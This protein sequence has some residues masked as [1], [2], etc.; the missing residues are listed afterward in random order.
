MHLASAIRALA[1]PAAAALLLLGAPA[2]VAQSDRQPPQPN[3]VMFMTDD[4]S[5]STVLP[6]VMPNLFEL[7]INRGSS[8]NDFVVTTPLCCPSRATALT[9][10]YGHNNRVLRNAYRLLADKRN[11]LPRWLQLA[12]Y[13]TAHVG[14]FLNGYERFAE[15]ARD[16]APG[17]DLWFT[18]LQPRQYYNWKA[19]KNGKLRRFGIADEHNL[20]DVTNR[21]AVDW[22]RKL[23]RRDEP[24]Y[25]QLD[26][27][28]PHG[29]PGRD[30]SCPGAPAPSPRDQ[31]FFA[32]EPLPRPPNFNEA[33]VSDK[34]AFIQERPLM[35]AETIERTAVRYRCTLE[36]LR[37]VDRGI[38]RVY[39][40]V[41]RAGQL[42]RTI[43]IFSSDNGFFFGEHRIP[44]GKLVPYEETLRMPLAIRT[45]PRYRNRAPRRGT[46]G[47]T[48]ANIDLAPTILELAGAQPCMP[49]GRCR[50]MD[51]RSL[52]PLLDGRGGWPQDR[53]IVIE[54]FDCS[55]RGIRAADQIL[56]EH[57]SGAIPPSGECVPTET[58]H[59]DLAADPYQLENLFP[60]PR[61]SADAARQTELDRRLS[62]LR[63]CA[64]VAGRDPAPSGGRP[65]C[66]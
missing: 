24:F 34:P 61:R 42:N 62:E 19:S 6:R 20:I 2:A 27:F 33:D 37:G 36:S 55:Y 22:T 41:E 30:G 46:I 54:L 50:V 21:R 44:T 3:I 26:F 64:G 15:R 32:D 29:G 63:D 14:K 58:E 38:R 35:N 56:L 12:G 39:R 5:A 11:V 53:S 25:L 13:R 31:G 28:A 1:A 60:A 65:F 52:M 43:F 8:F 4:Q 40:Q 66:P 48:T 47:A 16:V 59:Y 57:G 23:T 7:V 45:P 51:G 17:W 10:Q 9:G 49:N 18:Q